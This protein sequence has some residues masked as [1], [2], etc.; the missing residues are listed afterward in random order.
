MG[1][2]RNV[3]SYEPSLVGRTLR[4]NTFP[5][6]PFLMLKKE[7]RNLSLPAT[8]RMDQIEGFCLD[9]LLNLMERLR[10]NV[11]MTV[12]N[13]TSFGSIDESGTIGIVK[14]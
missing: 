10:F 14:P 4:V 1:G 5:S 2:R 6:S 7:W 13:S 12:V 11:E 3:I 9:I 8:V